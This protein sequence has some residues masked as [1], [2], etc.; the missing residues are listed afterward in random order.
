VLYTRTAAGTG[1]Y[2]LIASGYGNGAG[3]FHLAGSVGVDTAVG[4]TSW[5]RVKAA[6]R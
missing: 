6:Y 5:G 2:Y 1:R 3:T 4:L